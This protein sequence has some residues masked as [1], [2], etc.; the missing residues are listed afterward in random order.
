MSA[1]GFTPTSDVILV[2][3]DEPF[4][5]S[6]V[7]GILA[8]AGFRVLQAGGSSEALALARE[9]S[10][11]IDLIVCD[12]IMP[13]MSG[14]RLAERL[15]AIHPEA[16]FLFMAGLPDSP[17]ISQLVQHGHAFLPKPFGSQELIARV[18]QTL[19]ADGNAAESASY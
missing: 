19:G 13:G 14:P 15:H 16:R 7:A 9:Q 11:Q 6:A 5:L 3:D 17:D 10:G 8:R 2:I 1:S 4:V 18:R 12:V